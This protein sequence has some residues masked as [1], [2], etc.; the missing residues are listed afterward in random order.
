MSEPTGPEVQATSL[1]AEAEGWRLVERL[2]AAE[3]E[4]EY[5]ELKHNNTD[6]QVHF[7]FDGLP[8]APVHT[9]R[10]SALIIACTLLAL[11]RAPAQP[12]GATDH[13]TSALTCH[14]SISPCSGEANNCLHPPCAHG[15]R[16]DLLTPSM[17]KHLSGVTAVRTTYDQKAG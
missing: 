7:E 13:Q 1:P 11:L 8:D 5:L 6:P 3:G 10:D 14:N 4:S 16:R 12:D 15:A 2:L 9:C 17:N